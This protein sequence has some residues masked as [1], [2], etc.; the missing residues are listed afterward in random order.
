MATVVERGEPPFDKLLPNL[1]S[2]LAHRV[3][4]VVAIAVTKALPLTL[5][6]Y[7]EGKT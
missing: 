5:P 2:A 6:A 7:D 4:A 1:R 3:R